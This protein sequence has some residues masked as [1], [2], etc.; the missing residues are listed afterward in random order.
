VGDSAFRFAGVNRLS[1]ASTVSGAG[2]VHISGDSSATPQPKADHMA[3]QEA[4]VCADAIARSFAGMQ[5]DQAPVTN[6]ACFFTNAM[7]QASWLEAVFQYNPATAAMVASVAGS[8]ASV[9]W[10]AGI[11]KDMNTWFNTLMADSFA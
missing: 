3:N 8:G 11:F 2:K 4:K 6:S 5:P 7:T 9:G 10:N 1:Y